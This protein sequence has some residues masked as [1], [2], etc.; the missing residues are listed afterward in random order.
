MHHSEPNQIISTIMAKC[1]I[2]Q[3]FRQRLLTD[4]NATLAAEGM[5]IPAGIKVNVLE[6]T[7]NV[8]NYVL[9]P[10][11]QTE[12]SDADLDAVA[13]GGKVVVMPDGRRVPYGDW[14]NL[15]WRDRQNGRGTVV[16]E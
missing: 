13:G 11:P 7:S 1:Q 3:D 5:A 2:D 12:L 8:I 6:N 10:N 4:A 16:M 15:N 9:P 14:I